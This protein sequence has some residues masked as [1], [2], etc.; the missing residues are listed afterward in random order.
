MRGA[1][2]SNGTGWWGSGI[3]GIW[4]GSWREQAGEEPLE[5]TVMGGWAWSSKAF[6]MD[7][8][9]TRII[10]ITPDI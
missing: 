1:L 7:V 2:C 8:R 9:R 4:H 10:H 6:G 5:R 3:W